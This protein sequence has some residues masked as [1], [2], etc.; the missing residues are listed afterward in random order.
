MR[1][2]W[3]KRPFR[4]TPYRPGE[5]LAPVMQVTPEGGFY[6]QT[7]FDVTPFSPSQRYLAATRLPFQ[8]RM[9]VLGD[10]AEVCVIDLEEQTIQSV[11]S[12]RCWGFQTGANV[13]WGATDRRLY[14]ND[15]IGDAAVC[16]R[17][18]LETRE[19]RAFAGPLYSIAPDESC[20]IGFPH[21]QRD[22]TQLGYGVP[23][24]EPGNPRR[25]P[26][27]AATDEGIWRT[28]LRTNEKTLL[29]S[30]ADV[31][32]RVPSAPPRPGG[33][34]YFWHS[35]FNRQGTRV[36]QV[37]R[38]LHPQMPATVNP[39][40]FTF[41]PDGSDIRF[42]QGGAG[43]ERLPVWGASGGHPN[44]HADG[45]HVLRHMKADGVAKSRYWQFRFDGSETRCLSGKIEGRGHPSIEPRGRFIVTDQRQKGEDGARME[46]RL[47][48]LAAEEER[49][50]CGIPTIDPS[51][52]P[53]SVFRVDGHPA[54]SRDFTKVC[55]QAAPHG[56]RQLFIADVAE[57]VAG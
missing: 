5:T 38:Y 32:A 29:V 45:V 57:I 33:A 31:A 41:N 47:V 13:H 35:K 2:A 3:K 6:V 25:L 16:V 53:D 28:D 51:K 7:Y 10:A 36:M 15:V 52:Y 21:E 48:D 44:W 46:I 34:Y 19:T 14:A 17:I 43:S 42:A 37:L 50:V 26:P 20:V 39:M 1:D 30:L 23:P 40:V 49:I 18:D 4:L 11:Y 54:W 56:A 12:T 22:V 55:F 8:D 27:G 24:K 9:P